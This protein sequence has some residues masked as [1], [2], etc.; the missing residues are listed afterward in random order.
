METY[1]SPRGPVR[2]RGLADGSWVDCVDLLNGKSLSELIDSFAYL[3]TIAPEPSTPRSSPV[4]SALRCHDLMTSSRRFNRACGV[5]NRLNVT[6]SS[7]N[8]HGDRRVVSIFN[9]L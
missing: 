3:L 1:R 2:A 5:H 8:H 9:L 4:P 6:G 7:I